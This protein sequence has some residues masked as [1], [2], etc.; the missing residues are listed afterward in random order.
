MTARL[1]PDA[2]LAQPEGPVPVE[3]ADEERVVLLELARTALAAVTGRTTMEPLEEALHAAT[4]RY[5][6]R[7]AVFVTLTEGG[8]LRGCMGGLVAERP[9]PEAVAGAACSAALRDPRFVPLSARELPD[10]HIE[11]SVLGGPVRLDRPA[12][13]RPGIDGVI[14]ER[15][16]AVA[17]L[18]PEVADHFGWGGLEMITAVCR[19]AGLPG[20]AWRDP[21]TRLFVF[22]TARF[23]GPALE[24]A[25]GPGAAARPH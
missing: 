9:I 14:V 20:D 18:L 11:V 2:R 13:L 22:R 17:L 8:E 25:E 7:A 15:G 6:E 24:P 19:K 3:V 16:P 5:R 4:A 10:V 21:R 1:S 23:G 12:D